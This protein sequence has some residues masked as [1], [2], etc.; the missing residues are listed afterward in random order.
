VE[1]VGEWEGSV[2]VS[3]KYADVFAGYRHSEIETRLDEGWRWG[4][5]WEE[6]ERNGNIH[7]LIL[8]VR[9]DVRVAG[10]PLSAGVEASAM[11]ED[12]GALTGV[13]YDAA[14]GDIGAALK[15]EWSRAALSAGYRL[16]RYRFM[17]PRNVNGAWFDRRRLHGPELVLTAEF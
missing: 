2:G 15:W 16:R 14:H 13:G 8:G 4:W 5:I 1:T 10:S 7:G 3:L 17:P 6:F 9:S 11:P 12:T